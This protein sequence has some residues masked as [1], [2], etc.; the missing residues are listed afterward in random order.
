M[1]GEAGDGGGFSQGGEAIR[2]GGPI[3]EADEA[4]GLD[5]GGIA[6]GRGEPFL[7]RLQHMP[8]IAGG[9]LLA[10]VVG[11]LE[12]DLFADADVAAFHE[13]EAA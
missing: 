11:A 3:K 2:T 1:L 10:V 13:E 12:R 5:I 4:Q 7:I 9:G 8:G 6:F